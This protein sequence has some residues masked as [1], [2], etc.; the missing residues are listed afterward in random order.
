MRSIPPEPPLVPINAHSGSD[1]AVKSLP[2][3]RL[4]SSNPHDL[5]DGSISLAKESLPVVRHGNVDGE[6][7]IPYNVCGEETC[8]KAEIKNDGLF[9]GFRGR[10]VFSIYSACLNAGTHTPSCEL[11]TTP[12]IGV[13][14][15]TR[16]RPD[17]FSGT[18]EKL[19]RY[20]LSR[21]SCNLS[22]YGE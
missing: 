18:A 11:S 12:T 22:M 14:S 3:M 15:F 5:K 2:L 20:W 1:L 16:C 7:E 8:P 19:N 6:S 10:I 4:L 13:L 9:L 17:F 21:I